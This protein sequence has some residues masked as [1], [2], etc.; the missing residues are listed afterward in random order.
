MS[1]SIADLLYDALTLYQKIRR[2]L[3]T[4]YGVTLTET[5]RPELVAQDHFFHL[6]A[7][8]RCGDLDLVMD[9]FYLSGRVSLRFSLIADNDTRQSIGCIHNVNENTWRIDIGLKPTKGMI[10]RCGMLGHRAN[11]V[12]SED[13]ATKFINQM[14]LLLK[15]ETK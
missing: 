4:D 12:V 11:E 15:E 6:S 1:T 14:A 2:T 7:S 5:V 10:E 8:M 3:R 13:Q 9:L